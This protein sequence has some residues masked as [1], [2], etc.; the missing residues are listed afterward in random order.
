MSADHDHQRADELGA[1]LAEKALEIA[2]GD[3]ELAH[4]AL[5]S[6]CVALLLSG[7][8]VVFIDAPANDEAPGND[9]DED[10]PTAA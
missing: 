3:S 4:E 2:E 7:P 1:V 6:A 9:N 8:G 10:G 5:A